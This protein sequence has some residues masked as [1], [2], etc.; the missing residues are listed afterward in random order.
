MRTRH[1][2][3]VRLG[4]ISKQPAWPK[5][6]GLSIRAYMGVHTLEM[7]WYWG[8]RWLLPTPLKPTYAQRTNTQILWWVNPVI[9]SQ[10]FLW[11]WGGIYVGLLRAR[12]RAESSRGSIKVFISIGSFFGFALFGFASKTSSRTP[13]RP[14]A[15]LPGAR[16]CCRQFRVSLV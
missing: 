13:L 7:A 11:K 3:W 5:T 9:W 12:S 6:C 10:R 2:C 14:C 16:V 8:F 4:N 15:Y 1:L